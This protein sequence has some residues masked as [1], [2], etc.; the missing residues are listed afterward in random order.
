MNRCVPANRAT[1]ST[2]NPLAKTTVAHDGHVVAPRDGR[3]A[4]GKGE[5]AHRVPAG[6]P[7]TRW[8]VGSPSVRRLSAAR[9]PLEEAEES[10]RPLLRD[11]RVVSAA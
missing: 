7:E 11:P 5:L 2:L 6:G 9:K 1:E 8:A 3:K 4:S 10:P